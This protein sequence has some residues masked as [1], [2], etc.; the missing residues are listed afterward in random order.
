MVVITV[1]RQLMTH[2]YL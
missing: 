2:I 1:I